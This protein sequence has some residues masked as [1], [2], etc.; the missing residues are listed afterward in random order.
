[1]SR[2]ATGAK[3]ICSATGSR[4]VLQA[5]SVSCA[6]LWLW[7]PAYSGNPATP[8]VG[9]PEDRAAD[10][11]QMWQEV[12]ENYVYLGAKA[13]SWAEAKRRYAAQVENVQTIDSWTSVL[14]SALT[15]LADFH[16]EV[17]PRPNDDWRPV[18]TCA[19]IWAE[20][21]N[22][23]A[24]VTGVQPGGN[25]ARA[26]ILPGDIILKIGGRVAGADIAADA[27][28]LLR[29]HLLLQ[30]LAG[31]RG[32]SVEI[33]L[34]TPDRVVRSIALESDCRVDRPETLVT[35]E[36]VPSG[37][38][39]IRFNNSLG[40]TD[41]VTAFDHALATLRDVPGL[42]IDLRDIPSGGNSTV[43]LGVLG[44]FVGRRAPYQ[45]HRIPNFGRPD[46]ERVWLEEV[47]PRGPFQY[48]K[49]VV[50]LADHWTGSMG[51]GI[52]VG[53][54]AL[55]RAIVV[56]TSLARLNGSVQTV[57]LE[58][59]HINVNIPEEQIFHVNGVPRHEWN[60]PVLVDLVATRG[61]ADA[62]LAMAEKVLRNQLANP[63][64]G[65]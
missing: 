21:R 49:P 63:R 29:N 8:T 24:L 58:H 1:M 46:V 44:R 28:P 33:D 9:S 64:A 57:T 26:G 6:T 11:D 62:E 5:L 56:G 20:W 16:V 55:H 54:D 12:R 48:T 39:L 10:F 61:Q 31:R 41:T 2:W 53:F 35:F 14:A 3:G 19:M 17:D 50:V 60:P 52:A 42:I 47:T 43:A 7:Q 34:R 13:E 40:N 59:T 37:Y 36:R 27:A 22:G 32:S 30:Q 45:M 38:G 4:R 51:E 18:P 15:E 65:N 23:Q 25:A